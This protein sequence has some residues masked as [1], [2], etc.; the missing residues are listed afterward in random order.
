ME[1]NNVQLNILEKNQKTLYQAF[2]KAVKLT[3]I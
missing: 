1:L 3:V 2:Q